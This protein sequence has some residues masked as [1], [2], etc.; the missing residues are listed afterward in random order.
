MSDFYS[1][2]TSFI[3]DSRGRHP[4]VS[5]ILPTLFVGEYPRVEDIAWLKREFSISAIFSLQDN[6]DL[7]VKGLTL[8]T[9]TDECARHQ[10][11][12]RR[13]PVAD[14]NCES[15]AL[16]LPS[17]LQ[18]LH[19]LTQDSHTTFLHCN[20]GCNRAPTLAIA[21]LHVYHSMTLAEA[22]DFF[23]ARRPCGPYM[24]LLYEHFGRSA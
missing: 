17:A 19:T 10:I 4:E 23:K 15:L 16:A 22:R 1:L 11:E 2:S 12:F 21:Y 5:E 6:E 18:T 3:G 14:F 7:H 9:L 13:A 24:E 20:A 8:Y